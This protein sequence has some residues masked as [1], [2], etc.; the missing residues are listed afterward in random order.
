VQR[1]RGRPL[2]VVVAATVAVLIL[3]FPPWRACA[4]RTTTRYATVSNVAPQ[5]VVD[6]VRWTLAFAP[7]YAPPRAISGDRM[8]DLAARTMKGDAGAR[9]EL[10]RSTEES[11]RR[12]HAPEVLRTAGE[13]W[14]DSVL[15]AAGMSSMSS[16]DVTFSVDQG[17]ILTRLG[18]IAAIAFLL[19]RRARRKNTL[20]V[21][22]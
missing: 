20:A 21:T 11:E 17:W 16:Y 6:T 22:S 1:P 18:T 4:I 19:D 15:T 2:I 5:V 9:S 13:L 10:R 12:F 3:L 14:R 7:L 8:R